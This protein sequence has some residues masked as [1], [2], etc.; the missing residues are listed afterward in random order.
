[1]DLLAEHWA[2]HTAGEGDVRLG[3]G[4]Q[5]VHLTQASFSFSEVEYVYSKEHLTFKDFNFQSFDS[6]SQSQISVQ[7]KSVLIRKLDFDE[8]YNNQRYRFDK[9]EIN[10]P[11]FS[12]ALRARTRPR[13]DDRIRLPLSAI[14]TQ[15]FGEIRL[16]TATINDAS[17]Q[18][19]LVFDQ[20][21]VRA[22]I[23]DVNLSL[24]NVEVLSDTTDILF[25]DLQMDLTETD[26]N[27]NDDVSLS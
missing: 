12:G 24:H 8:L 15:T 2:E 13:S 11:K 7:G 10:E 14:L 5:S 23:P 25:G 22:H 6:A 9:I 4:G 16:D 19:V 3:I 17:F 1:I 18:M 21:S 27:L 26:I 20:D